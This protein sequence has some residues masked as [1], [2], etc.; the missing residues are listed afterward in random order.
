MGNSVSRECFN[1]LVSFLERGESVKMIDT[2]ATTGHYG[3]A[4]GWQKYVEGLK[5]ALSYLKT[6]QGNGSK[7][8]E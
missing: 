5:K 1:C 6:I 7:D 2:E 8:A 4:C 3:K